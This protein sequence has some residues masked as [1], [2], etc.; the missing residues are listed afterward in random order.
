MSFQPGDV[1]QLKSGGPRMTIDNVDGDKVEC[2]WF[3]KDKQQYG[4][5]KSVLLSKPGPSF[6]SARVSR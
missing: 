6:S 2:C 4:T 5:F 3:E 1:V